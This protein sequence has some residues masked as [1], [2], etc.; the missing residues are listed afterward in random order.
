LGVTGQTGQLLSEEGMNI[1]GGLPKG[2][3]QIQAKN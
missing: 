1:K 3:N 2:E